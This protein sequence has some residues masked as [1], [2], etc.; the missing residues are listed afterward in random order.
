M[1][2]ALYICTFIS[3]HTH[4]YQRISIGHRKHDT[5][6]FVCHI[7]VFAPVYHVSRA[8]YMHIYIYTHTRISRAQ[9][10]R[11]SVYCMSY[12]CVRSSLSRFPRPVCAHLHICTYISVYP[13]NKEHDTPLM[14]EIVYINYNYQSKT[15]QMMRLV[16]LN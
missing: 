13:G 10:T 14:E 6:Y 11:Y 12:I 1:F 2:P 7:Y 4:V 8:L 9:K 15:L 16:L 3:T 5:L